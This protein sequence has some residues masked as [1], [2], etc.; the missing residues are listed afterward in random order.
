MVAGAGQV[1]LVLVRLLLQQTV[2]AVMVLPH[3]LQAHP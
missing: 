1:P 3:Q 2:L